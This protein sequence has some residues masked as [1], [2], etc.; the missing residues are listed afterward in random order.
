MKAKDNRIGRTLLLLGGTIVAALSSIAQD[1]GK[2]LEEKNKEIVV[3]WLTGFWS[4]NYNPSI[5]DELAAPDMMLQYSLHKPRKGHADI[6]DFMK[7]FRD[8]F[9]D[10]AFEGAYPLLADGDYVIARWIGGGTHTGTAF[11]DWPV[12]K[13]PAATGRKMRFTGTTVF[14]VVDGKVTEEIGLDD[15]LTTLLQLGL[16]KEVE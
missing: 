9:P 13:L 3:K 16:V 4:A 10:L 12:G 15:G 2:A 7:K 14:K 1:K 11:G 6:K 5:I 8:A